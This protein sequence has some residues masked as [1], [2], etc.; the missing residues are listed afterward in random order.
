MNLKE[1]NEKRSTTGQATAEIRRWPSAGNGTTE[2]G[3]P[4]L[5]RGEGREREK[6]MESARER[7]R[8]KESLREGEKNTRN[9]RAYDERAESTETTGSGQAFRKAA[10]PRRRCSDHHLRLNV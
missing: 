4:H 5:E 6:V 1:Q 7:E 10:K 2:R 9:E 8:K 3:E